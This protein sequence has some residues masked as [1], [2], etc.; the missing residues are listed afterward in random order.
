MLLIRLAISIFAL[1]LLG[2]AISLSAAQ[3]EHATAA[4]DATLAATLIH[5]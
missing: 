5:Q 3:S 1:T 2:L 4:K